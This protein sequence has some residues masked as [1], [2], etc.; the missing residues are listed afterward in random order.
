MQSIEISKNS[1]HLIVKDYSYKK[2]MKKVENKYLE[3][4][5]KFE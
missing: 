4:L 2:E 1:R 3:I 5:N